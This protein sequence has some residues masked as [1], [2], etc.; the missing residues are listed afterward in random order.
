MDWKEISWGK[1]SVNSPAQVLSCIQKTQISVTSQEKYDCANTHCHLSP[2]HL[3]TFSTAIKSYVVAFGVLHV[4]IP[5]IKIIVWEHIG[6]LTAVGQ[7]EKCKN[8]L[9]ALP[10][11]NVC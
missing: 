11:K 2:G 10:F 4:F 5:F 3:T 7:M 6:H 1:T 8:V 9:C